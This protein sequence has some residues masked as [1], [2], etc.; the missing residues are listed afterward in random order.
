MMTIREAVK[1]GAKRLRDNNVDNADHD[2]FELLSAINGMTR[3][4]YLVN[5]DSMLF[6]KYTENIESMVEI[7]YHQLKNILIKGLRMFRC[8]IFWEKHISMDMNSK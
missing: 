8:S 2:S 5:G 6:L 7:I 3:T 1:W 4:F